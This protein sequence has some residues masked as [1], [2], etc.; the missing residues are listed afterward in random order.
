MRSRVSNFFSFHP[1]LINK[2]WT[3]NMFFFIKLLPTKTEFF[4]S[5]L[6]FPVQILFEFPFLQS[7]SN[8]NWWQNFSRIMIG[9]S[10]SR[11]KHI[12][13]GKLKLSMFFVK[14]QIFDI[15]VKDERGWHIPHVSL[16][17]SGKKQKWNKLQ[18]GLTTMTRSRSGEVRTNFYNLVPNQILFEMNKQ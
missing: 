7:Q 5:W 13:N 8:I 3:F 15:N 18:V 9:F 11:V 17:S 12:S 16:I 1:S 14:I 2:L 6:C 4:D 10:G